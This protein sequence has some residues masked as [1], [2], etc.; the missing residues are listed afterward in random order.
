MSNLNITARGVRMK[1]CGSRKAVLSGQDF[2]PMSNGRSTAIVRGEP[3]GTE[4]GADVTELDSGLGQT[5]IAELV[6][7]ARAGSQLAWNELVERLTPLLWGIARRYRLTH[8]DAADLV[9]TV[10]LR[11]VENLQHIREPR[12][13]ARWMITTCQREALRA[14]ALNARCRP[15]DITDP[16]DLLVQQADRDR[17]PGPAEAVVG[18]EAAAVLRAALS[19][20][21]ARQRQ[22]LGA[23]AESHGP[24]RYAHAA[25]ALSMPV[26]SLGPVRQRA[27]RRLRANPHVRAIWETLD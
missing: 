9:Q 17:S 13:V 7:R 19:E 18:R 5:S 21:P 3:V 2:C 14:G 23:L 20:L 26:G 25:K 11:L 15:H 8:S 24:A 4:T 10:W 27:L 1:G 12:A 6:T 16:S 22:V